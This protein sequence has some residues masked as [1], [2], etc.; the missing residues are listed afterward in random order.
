[1][2][3]QLE[4]ASVSSGRSHAIDRGAPLRTVLG[5]R[6]RSPGDSLL[7][8]RERWP[9]WFPVLMGVG[10]GIYFSLG[11]EPP[12]RLGTALLLLAAAGLGVAWWRG[13]GVAVPVAL[14]AVALGFAAAQFQALHVAAPVLA[15]RTGAVT[16]EGRLDAVDPLPT[17]ARLVIAPSRIDGIDAAHLPARVRVRVRRDAAVLPGV[18]LQ[19][20]AVLM[21]PPMPAMPGGYDFERRAWFDRIGGVGFALG[22]PRRIAPPAGA[23]VP[24]WRIAVEAVRSAVTARIRAA[25]PG[26]TG[27]I[28]AALITGDTHAI[29]PADAD[30]FRNAG[31][32][33]IL[34]IA[35]LH[36][37][38]VAGIVFFALR[39]LLALLP[40]V[41]LYHPT[42]KYA[43]AAAL[44]AIFGY[45]LLSGATVSS[46]RAFV[47]IGLALLAVLV[48]RLSVSARAV[49]FAA[50]II[51]LMSPESATGP[52][53]QM[54]FAA[55][56]A[57]IACYEAM[58]PVLTRWHSRA[59][60]LRRAGLYLVGIALTTVVATLATMPFTIYHFNRFALYSVVANALAVPITGF[61]VMPWA[62]I[63]CLAMPL[64][65]EALALGPMGWG[66]D[67]IVAIARMVT[68]WPGAVLAVPSLPQPALALVSFGGLWLCIWQRRWRW[69]GA[70]P[71][72]AGYFGL[73]LARPPDLLVAANAHVIA[74]RAPDGAYLP[75]RVADA[76]FVEDSWTQHAAAVLGAPWPED[77]SAG[78]GALRCDAMA[79]LYRAHGRVVALIRDGAA[80][81][82]ECGAVDLVVSPVAA[83]RICRHTRVIDRNDT[84]RRGGY[85][86]WL[87]PDRIRI[88]TVRG[89]QGARPWVPQ[90]PR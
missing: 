21:P 41:A 64:H 23:G 36:M 32:A 66:I 71:I 83:H 46:R 74:V 1:M 17:G 2:A 7:A 68:S 25:V 47:M 26:R 65:L 44:A 84:W 14:V 73:A 87:D 34:V 75:S 48:D 3:T 61:W 33:H 56:A 82:E 85:A 15:R 80:L 10:I 45:M 51:M 53:F 16:V 22:E 63:A 37:G 70:V 29:A 54:S 35:G 13:R 88:A 6:L 86:V 89:W 62:I 5:A 79:C 40:R 55:V 57:L 78:D 77:G 9:L 27:A 59:G 52:S 12:P 4:I 24:G 72:M 38:M 76:R 18:W 30:A 60:A 43:A 49:A 58:R 90:R 42:K 39:A 20:R 19:L 28:A 50:T 81:A 69:L 67:A 8:E 31:L 11:R